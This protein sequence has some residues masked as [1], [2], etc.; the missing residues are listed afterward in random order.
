MALGADSR[1]IVMTVLREGVQLVAVGLAIGLAGVWLS[2][3][4]IRVLVG[5]LYTFDSLT[6]LAV[7]AVLLSAAFLANL[8][9]A[10]SAAS[11]RPATALGVE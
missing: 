8:A 3:R 7:I 1:Q 6:C 4:P 11:R 10:L 5:S 2:A 9:P